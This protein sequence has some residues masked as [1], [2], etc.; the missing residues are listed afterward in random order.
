MIRFYD[1]TKLDDAGD[2]YTVLGYQAQRGTGRPADDPRY[3][4]PAGVFSAC[5]GAAIYRRSVFDEIGLFDVM[6]FAYLED[7]DVGYRALIYG[8]KNRYEPSAVVYHV[9]SGASGAVQY[10]DFKVRLSARNNRYLIYKNMPGFFRGVNALPLFIGGLVKRRF[11]KKRGFSEAYEEGRALAVKDREKLKK[12][13]FSASHL[14]NYVKI[15]FLEIGYTFTYVF[16][17]LLR[18]LKR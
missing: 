8:Y 9:G 18:R 16:E 4:K 14:M 3:L 5:A 15:E 17:Y 10:S 6:H 12:V 1:R 13:P 11:F 7:I 2:L